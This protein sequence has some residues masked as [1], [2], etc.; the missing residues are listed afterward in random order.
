MNSIKQKIVD[1]TKQNRVN[2]VVGSHRVQV[3]VN[4]L[5]TALELIA[6]SLE[7][8]KIHNFNSY[9][10]FENVYGIE[11]QVPK[12][13]FINDYTNQWPNRNC[14]FRVRKN[15]P[16]NRLIE[17]IERTKQLR[18]KVFEISRQIHSIQ[19]EHIYEDVKESTLNKIKKFKINK[20]NKSK[21][22]SNFRKL[23]KD[24]KSKNS[25]ADS[26]TLMFILN[27]VNFDS[28]I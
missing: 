17:N 9:D 7:Q 8:C 24:L 11:R 28:T 1:I 16:N 3:S 5:T 13:A 23:F 19:D 14:C 12:N 10:L 22:K 4:N 2:V 6:R 20:V 15:M 26:S 18:S 27:E 21:L 25:T